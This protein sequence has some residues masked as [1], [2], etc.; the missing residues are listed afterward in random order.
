MLPADA[1]AHEPVPSRTLAEAAAVAGVQ[2]ETECEP[3]EAPRV[4][5]KLRLRLVGHGAP[6]SVMVLVSFVVGLG[7]AIAKLR[8]IVGPEIVVTPAA[9]HG[10]ETV[11][12]VE[13][14][15]TGTASAKPSRKRKG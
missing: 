1:P 11:G 6:A 13:A 2:L 9:A 5:A 15:D 4:A 8:A 10:D 7:R 12:L 14:L 3:E